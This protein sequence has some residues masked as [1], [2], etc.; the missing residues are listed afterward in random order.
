MSVIVPGL[1][2]VCGQAGNIFSWVIGKVS[3][4]KRAI[5]LAAFGLDNI[6]L[7][8]IVNIKYLNQ[9]GLD[10]IV[11]DTMNFVVYQ[12][13]ESYSENG[14]SMTLFVVEV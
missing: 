12:I 11:D 1:G 3:K 10:V 4:P 6:Q 8:D 14:P 5:G 13:E 9:D 2:F 7:G